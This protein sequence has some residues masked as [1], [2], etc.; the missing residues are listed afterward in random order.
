VAVVV[1]VEP[2]FTLV[3]SVALPEP[4]IPPPSKRGCIVAAGL[5]PSLQAAAAAATART[6]RERR[7]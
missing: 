2:L 3:V 5:A 1:P 7:K 4:T 6:A